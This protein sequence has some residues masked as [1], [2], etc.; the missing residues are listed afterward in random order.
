LHF[1]PSFQFGEIALEYLSNEIDED[2]EFYV[3][4]RLEEAVKAGIYW[5]SILRLKNISLPEKAQAKAEWITEKRKAKSRVNPF[6]ISEAND[7]TRKT[8]KLAIKH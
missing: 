7:V 3:D 6:R 4:E 1:D 2:G 8:I 5:K